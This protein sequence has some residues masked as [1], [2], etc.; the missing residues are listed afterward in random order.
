MKDYTGNRTQPCLLDGPYFPQVLSASI[1]AH[2]RR[3]K[4]QKDF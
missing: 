3:K 4:R 1:G 2:R